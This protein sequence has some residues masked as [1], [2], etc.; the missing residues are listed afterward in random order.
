MAEVAGAAGDIVINTDYVQRNYPRVATA[1]NVFNGAM[2]VVGLKNLITNSGIR[3]FATNLPSQVKQAFKDSKEFK[4]IIAAQYLKWKIAIA[5]IP[6]ITTAEQE[7]IT[8]QEKIWKAFGVGGDVIYNIDKLITD[9][10]NISKYIQDIRVKAYF[11]NNLQLKSFEKILT[12]ADPEVLRWID[13]MTEGDID[14]FAEMVRGFKDNPEKF[15]LSIKTIDDFVGTPSRPGFVKFWSLTPKMEEGLATIRK[16]K[17]EG[18]LLPTGNATEIQLATAQNYTAWGNFLNNPMRYGEHFGA[19]AER[20]LVHLKEGLIELRKVPERNMMNKQ[21][22]SGRAYSQQEFDNLFVGKMG[23]EVEINKG[24]VSSSLDENV[25]IH[26]AIKTSDKTK[27]IKVIRRIKTKTGVY[28]DDLSDYGENLGNIRHSDSPPIEQI[29]KEVLMEEGL[30][31]QI[32][33]PIPFKGTDGKT[34]YY[35]DFIELGKQ[36]N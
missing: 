11:S 23:T 4:S 5:E 20:A 26:F 19:Y 8:K 22:Y 24:F 16:L 29:Q 27:N 21:V 15:K 10:P 25:S 33:E 30:F 14:D 13:K 2:G 6:D 1:T 18:K 9:Y 17:E 35:I 7:L 36:L 3:S 34:W 28:L 31:K 12:T 32:S